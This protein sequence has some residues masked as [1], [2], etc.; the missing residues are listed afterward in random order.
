MRKPA[1]CM[2]ENKDADQLRR[3]VCDAVDISLAIR[4]KNKGTDQHTNLPSLTSIFIGR[5]IKN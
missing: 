3:F 2:C 4:M 1:F 5:C